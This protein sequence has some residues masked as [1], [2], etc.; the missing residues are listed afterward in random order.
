LQEAEV[1]I[2]AEVASWMDS[3]L[4]PPTVRLFY[5]FQHILSLMVI[6]VCFRFFSQTI[7]LIAPNPSVLSSFV[8]YVRTGAECYAPHRKFAHRVAALGECLNQ[9]VTRPIGMLNGRAMLK[10]LFEGNGNQII[11]Y[12]LLFVF[13][14]LKKCKC[15]SG[16]VSWR[17]E[18]IRFCE[19]LLKI[20][21]FGIRQPRHFLITSKYL[22]HFHPD[23]YLQARTITHLA[24]I[25]CVVLSTERRTEMS[26]RVDSPDGKRSF[27]LI[28]P[29]EQV[30]LLV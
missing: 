5:P 26:L 20:N 22:Y 29:T 11:F 13:I 14:I 19:Q 12:L 24:H 7:H 17:T 28:A 23:F 1:L 25:S 6:V 10:D 3:V 9:N 21:E 27:D 15:E 2:H 8:T 16:G 18:P 4:D 30:F